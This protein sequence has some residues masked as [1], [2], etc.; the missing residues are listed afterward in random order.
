MVNTRTHQFMHPVGSVVS[1]LLDAG[2]H[3]TMLH[4]HDAVPWRM[5][6]ALEEGADGM[7]RWPDKPWLPLSYSLKA[8]KAD[9]QV[10]G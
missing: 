5:F 7:F 2:L 9:P 8:V 1:A 6:A 10:A 4:E 3:I